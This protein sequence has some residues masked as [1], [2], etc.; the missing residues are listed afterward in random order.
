M[1]PR[2]TS[3]KGQCAISSLHPLYLQHTDYNEA[4]DDNSQHGLRVG[5]RFHAGE[6]TSG[7][8]DESRFAEILVKSSR[9]IFWVFDCKPFARSSVVEVVVGTN[10]RQS[11]PTRCGR[12]EGLNLPVHLQGRR[13][14][15][16]VVGS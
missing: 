11:K 3:C 8:A 2:T 1:N 6:V 5:I 15:H 16:S 4:H 7:N 12:S 14:L 10:E 13:E 9:M